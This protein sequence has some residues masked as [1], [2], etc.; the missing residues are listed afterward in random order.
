MP[1]NKTCVVYA[2]RGTSGIEGSTSTAIGAHQV[3]PDKL[4][5]LI[6]GDLSFFY[7][8]NALWSNYIKPNFRIILLNNKGGGIFR[9]L[10]GTKALPHFE[11]FFET[12]HNRN[13]KLVS[14]DFGFK[15][16]FTDSKEGLEQALKNFYTITDHP[17]LLEV[18]TPR[19]LNDEILLN[20]FE[21][22]I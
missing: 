2:N 18:K 7:D 6:T 5:V 11:T 10:P 14:E 13:A 15:Y 12:Q 4:V 20:F 21:Y 1:L 17:K 8:I 9:I 22:L 3:D 16:N 19:E